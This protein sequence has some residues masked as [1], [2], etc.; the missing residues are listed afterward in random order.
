MKVISTGVC[1]APMVSRCL[2]SVRAASEHLGESVEH[3][4]Q[5]AGPSNARAHFDFLTEKIGACAPEE[6][7]VAV[8]LDDT[9]T[10]DAL[11]IVARLHELGAWVTYGS[12]KH[13]DGRPGFAAPCKAETCRRD[14]W[15]ASHLKTFRAGLFNRIKDEDLKMGGEWLPHARDLALMFPLLE[16]A[17]ERAVFNPATVYVYNYAASGEFK[18]PEAVR[19]EERRCVAHVRGL[20]TY[21]RVAAL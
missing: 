17:R 3:I 1:D 11:K 4:W 12:F 18:G 2:S 14:P 13:A 5:V 15:T 21:E 10:P 19:A 20:K 16:M 9:I 7:V 8:D 6:I